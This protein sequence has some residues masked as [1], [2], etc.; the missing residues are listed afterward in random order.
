MF[1]WKQIAEYFEF[2][3]EMD[4]R[5]VE[6][7]HQL[8]EKETEHVGRLSLDL[9]QVTRLDTAAAQLLAVLAQGDAIEGIVLSIEA[10]D[11]LNALGLLRIVQTETA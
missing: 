2:V 4:A 9:S 7:L 3:G 10:K 1:S 5:S 6:D 8:F 11:T